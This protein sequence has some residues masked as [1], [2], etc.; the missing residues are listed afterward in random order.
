[1]FSD[2]LALAFMAL[3]F[4][5]ALACIMLERR[6]CNTSAA[7]TPKRKPGKRKRVTEA[8]AKIITFLL[9]EGP[10]NTATTKV[11]TRVEK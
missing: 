8:I 5:F 9:G 11:T 10:K 4:I 2:C 1:M 7:K 3:V 6:N